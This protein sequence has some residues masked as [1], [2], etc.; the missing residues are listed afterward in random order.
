VGGGAGKIAVSEQECHS[1][2]NF[3]TVDH[4]RRASSIGDLVATMT[5]VNGWKSKG[6][7]VCVLALG[8][9]IFYVLEVSDIL[10]L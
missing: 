7:L 9:G 4:V 6:M 8:C 10:G 1:E 3:Q 2:P 5:A